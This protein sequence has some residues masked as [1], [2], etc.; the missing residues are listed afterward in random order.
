MKRPTLWPILAA[1]VMLISLS[2]CSSDSI[3]DKAE[4]VATNVV[5]PEDKIIEIEILERINDYRISK[6]L[7][8]LQG[9]DIIKSQTYSHTDYMIE[10]E[11]ISHD[12][13]H[14]RRNFLVS[15]AGAI[16]VSEN[17]AYGYSTAE[18]VVV[19]WLNSDGHRDAIEGN[20]THFNV[21]AEKNEEG[22]WYY[23][24]IFVKK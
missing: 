23:T 1:F 11:N 22:H 10:R 19:A 5:I 17:V 4:A 15:N 16:S 18:S 24:N 21:S 8:S 9:L 13:F 6:G 12:N 2:S 14:Q 3:D 7:N 20:F